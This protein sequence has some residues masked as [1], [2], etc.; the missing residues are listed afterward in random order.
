M[1]CRPVYNLNSPPRT[2]TAALSCTA[3]CFQFPPVT[4]DQGKR[5]KN[6]QQSDIQ[7]FS[8]DESLQQGKDK[9]E[10]TTTSSQLGNHRDELLHSVI[11]SHLA[12][13]STLKEKNI[14]EDGGHGGIDLNKTPLQ[15]PPKRKKHRPKVVVEGKLKRTP[16]PTASKANISKENPSGKRKYVRR[17]GLEGSTSSKQNET[18]R[19]EAS[20]VSSAA[21][22]CRRVLNFDLEDK[23]HN[24]SEKWIGDN[25]AEA[26]LK[27]KPFDLNLDCQDT[28]MS[29]GFNT[30]SDISSAKEGQ[31]DG[32]NAEKQ[33]GKRKSNLVH[34]NNQRP[35]EKSL[36][37]APTAPPPT[38]R[39][40]TLNVIARSLNLQN[41]ACQK[42]DQS[43]YSDGNQHIIGDGIGQTILQANTA[44]A[45]FDAA[46]KLVFQT[47]STS[48][49]EKAEIYEKRGS[50]RD[51]CH[52]SELTNPQSVDLMYSQFLSREISKT[53]EQK[54]DSSQNGIG[55]LEAHKK[56]KIENKC[57]GVASSISSSVASVQDCLRQV[58]S[59][60]SNHIHTSSS[61][62]C[63]FV[64]LPDSNLEMQNTFG[65]QSNE[66]ANDRCNTNTAVGNGFHEKKSSSK[67]YLRLWQVKPKFQENTET[68]SLNVVTGTTDYLLHPTPEV[69]AITPG[70]ETRTSL[71]DFSVQRQTPITSSSIQAFRK[72]KVHPEEN[73]KETRSQRSSRKAKGINQF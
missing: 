21:K 49:K 68:N 17:K 40:H 9:L 18:N 27:R 51:Y 46:R 35:A 58:E 6:R 11:A 7:N 61:S 54:K 47:L 70:N 5:L 52:I 3:S 32:Q 29:T 72:E 36:L 38:A 34:S 19:V 43:G 8:V 23:R 33:H 62:S 41:A 73:K 69:S 28:T 2:E 71:V 14:S 31:Q 44:S 37:L 30:Q 67:E 1:P 13:D 12:S 16:K 50:K 4:P 56:K 22:S 10:I 55:T 20:G 57:H 64:R 63:L 66:I 42:K 15:R 48:V 53:S 60:G 24:R 26:H 59:R 25:Q 45:K 39:D 65:K